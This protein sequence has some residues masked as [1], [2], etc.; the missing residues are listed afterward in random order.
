MTQSEG[1]A[2]LN[3]YA[4]QAGVSSRT[5]VE[6]WANA[7]FWGQNDSENKNILWD[8]SSLPFPISS[9]S[10][11]DKLDSLSDYLYNGTFSGSN[12]PSPTQIELFYKQQMISRIINSQWKYDDAQFYAFKNS[13]W[14]QLTVVWLVPRRSSS[15]SS[16]PMIPM[17]L[18]AHQSPNIIQQQMV[19]SI[20]STG[21]LS[22]LSKKLLW[23]ILILNI[24][25]QRTAF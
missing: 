2:A 16:A 1:L 25:I 4:T 3:E 19:G 11:A 14:K 5:A 21:M 15:L 10:W 24:D 6:T 12:L 17:T 18:P 7:T 9:K 22:S 20:I 13:S 8:S 23:S